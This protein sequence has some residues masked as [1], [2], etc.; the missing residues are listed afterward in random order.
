M[1]SI[2]GI[3]A[4]YR[5]KNP[6]M[7]CSFVWPVARARAGITFCG[8][9]LVKVLDTVACARLLVVLG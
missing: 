2:A 8:V 3:Q 9:P 5:V 7:L 4:A 6:L 1:G